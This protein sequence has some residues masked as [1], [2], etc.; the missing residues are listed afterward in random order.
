M[1]ECREVAKYNELQASALDKANDA[2][3][4]EAGPSGSSPEQAHI[5]EKIDKI[6]AE[7][8]ELFAEASS[9]LEASQGNNE[10]L[11]QEVD[12]L[13]AELHAKQKAKEEG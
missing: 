2:S 10:S 13:A 8:N 7:T 5:T 9:Q 6:L 4:R 12:A 3:A 11:A 1:K